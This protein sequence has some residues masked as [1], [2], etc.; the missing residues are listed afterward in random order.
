[1]VWM[2]SCYV[3]SYA[4]THP[5]EVRRLVVME[6]IFS[7]FTPPQLEGKAWWFVFHQ[8]PNVPEALVQGKELIYLSW[9]YHGFIMVLS[10]PYV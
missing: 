1:M 2:A 9:F 8:T 10:W 5:A 4:A 3:S 7:G 6:Y